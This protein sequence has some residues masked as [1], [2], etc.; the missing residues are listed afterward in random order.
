MAYRTQVL[1][2]PVY[3]CRNIDCPPNHCVFCLSDA[4]AYNYQRQY[5]GGDSHSPRVDDRRYRTY[6][7]RA[8]V[9]YRG[10]RICSGPM[11]HTPGMAPDCYPACDSRNVPYIW[12]SYE[13]PQYNSG[14]PVL[15][16]SNL[17]F[18]ARFP[19]NHI[20]IY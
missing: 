17:A 6:E 5:P 15:H 20:H 3:L 18:P 4:S 10:W 7:L 2:Q 11:Q 12:S 1:A 13:P 9:L 19:G 16:A 8:P 14:R